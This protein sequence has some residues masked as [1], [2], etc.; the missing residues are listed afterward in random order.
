MCNYSLSIRLERKSIK[1]NAQTA[2]FCLTFNYLCKK[3][4]RMRRLLLSIYAILCIASLS[5]QDNVEEIVEQ[6][7][8]DSATILNEYIDKLQ[9]L[10][11]Q[12]DSI[13]SLMVISVPNAY[14]YKL[15]SSPTL[16]SSPLHQA[17]SYADSLSADG[18]MQ[19]LYTMNRMLAQLYTRNPGLISQTEADIKA[20]GTFREDVKEKLHTKDKLADKVVDSNV[21][22]EMTD[23][24]EV[25]T[26]RPNFWKVSGN[27]A[28]HFTQNYISDNWYQGGESNYSG[29]TD[30]NLKVAFNNQRKVSWD[31]LLEFQ[32]GFQTTKAENMP[33]FRPTSN[34]VCLTSNFGYKAVKTLYYSLQARANTQVVRNYDNNKTVISDFFAPLDLTVAPGLKYDFAYGKKKRFT[35]TLNIAPLAYSMKHSGRGYDMRSRH[36]LRKDNKVVATL[37][38]FGP[39]IT[40]NTNLKICK[41]I[42]W[43]SK[44]YW[45]SDLHYNK[46]EWQNTINFTVTKLISARLYLFPRFDDSLRKNGDDEGK[47]TMFKEYLSVG[48][49]YNF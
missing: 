48:F 17:M 26:R 27:T 40:L 25:V 19:K 2:S 44:I 16:Y 45:F 13:D 47:F 20:K 22:P 14:Y 12:R 18:Q 4:E 41:Q 46:F 10:V 15:L 7:N 34:R 29:Q 6:E 5:A 23:D 1:K 9:K 24:I 31:N 32:L 11:S 38:N 33:T 39:N 21:V 42:S 8:V 43:D 35:G 49:N 3:N 28:L 37:H 36:G 30:F